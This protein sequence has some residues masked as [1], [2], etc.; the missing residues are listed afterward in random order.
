[1]SGIEREIKLTVPAEFVLPPL[2]DPAAD[3]FAGP[4]ETLELRATYFDTDDLRLAR[5]GASLRHRDDGWTV[6]LPRGVGEEGVLARD[7]LAVAGPEG[8]AAPPP[9][10]ALD[11]VRALTRG[12]PVVP[13]ADLLTTRQRV[14]LRRSDGTDVAEVVD[15][16]VEVHEPGS[17]DVRDEFREVEVELFAGA[18]DAHRTGVLTR[19]SAAGAGPVDPT[20]KVVR[21]LGSAAAAPPD[22]VAVP[23]ERGAAADLVVRGAIATSV[24]RLVSND[25]GVRI[26]EDPEA[27]HQARVATRRLRSDLRTLRALV[28]EQWANALRDEL[29]WLGDVLGVVRDTDVL[30]E[31]L[32]V[33]VARLPEVDRPSGKALVD[34]LRADRDRGREQ[35]L[36][37]LRS[38]RYDAL[39]ERLVVAA[40]RPRLLLRV[41]DVDDAEL[42][43]GL[44]RRPWNRLRGAVAALPPEPTDPQ[45]HEVR[46]LA[47]RTRYAAEAVAPAVGGRARALARALAGVQDELGEHQD[48]VI[49]GEWLRRGAAR[50]NDANVGFAAGLLA[51]M[52][53][54]AA[55][56]ARDTWRQAWA[57]TD[58]K[59]VRGWL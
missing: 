39:L 20:P 24:T 4:A 55:E 36:R 42:L 19:L 38:D 8:T 22:V 6:K 5:S 45:L 2:S 17:H 37:A 48:A 51:S 58:R 26:G 53:R 56:A 32:D 34:L 43:R 18:T 23:V 13:V 44:V 11:L 9:E 30:I 35:L 7:E 28:D 49:A 15:D 12:A 57:R 10:G 33:K 3:L 52:E 40:R 25:P 1:V 14:R 41:D 50:S 16:H 54:E 27:V 46:I 29:R 47:K 59:R 31:R 21:A